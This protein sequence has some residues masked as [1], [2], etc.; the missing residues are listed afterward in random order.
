MT[1]KYPH[2]QFGWK[3]FGAALYRNN[4]IFDSLFPSQNSVKLVPNDPQAHLNLGN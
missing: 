2:H 3:V 4:K 1:Q